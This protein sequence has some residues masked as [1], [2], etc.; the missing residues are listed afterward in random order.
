MSSSSWRW[1]NS[2]STTA[3]CINI[4]ASDNSFQ[5]EWICDES[6]VHIYCVVSLHQTKYHHWWYICVTLS[7]A[8]YVS[9]DKLARARQGTSRQQHRHDIQR[10]QFTTDSAPLHESTYY[11]RGS[12]R[13]LISG[14]N[15]DIPCAFVQLPAQWVTHSPGIELR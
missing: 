1:R 6:L 12:G 2:I 4:T 14:T 10:T 9:I 13:N 5:D 7:H 15:T 8:R 3:Y 11:Y